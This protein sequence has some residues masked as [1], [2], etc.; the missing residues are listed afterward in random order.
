MIE[1]KLKNIN[2]IWF[3]GLSGSGK[4][5]AS[6]FLESKINYSI[7]IEGDTVRKF[8]SADLGYTKKDRVESA[9]RNLEIAKLLIHEK[10]FPLISNAYLNQ[11]IINLA[12]KELILVIKI[13]REKNTNIK[14]NKNEKNVLGKDLIFENIKCLEILNDSSFKKSLLNLFLKYSF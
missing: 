7:K 8:L 2:G 11:R 4:S 3:C 10:K 1:K 13:V 5:F 9:R 6:T 14:F 12:N